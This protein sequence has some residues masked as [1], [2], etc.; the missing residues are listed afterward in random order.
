MEQRERRRRRAVQDFSKRPFGTP[1]ALVGERR[2]IDVF[3][4]QLVSHPFPTSA[5]NIDAGDP[6]A[7]ADQ[8]PKLSRNQP[9]ASRC[10]VR[11][12]GRIRDECGVGDGRAP[13]IRV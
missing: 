2:L 12:T 11:G 1:V 9:V 5:C 10:P 7:G 6:R 8:S 13:G 3:R 4:E